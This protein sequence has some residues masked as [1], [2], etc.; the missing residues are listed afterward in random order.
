MAVMHVNVLGTTVINP[1]KYDFARGYRLKEYVEV[2]EWAFPYLCFEEVG[3]YTIW[4]VLW[5]CVFRFWPI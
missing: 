3:V 5:N 4:T 2:T 1:R